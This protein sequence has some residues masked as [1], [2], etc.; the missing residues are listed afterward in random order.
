[1]GERYDLEIDFDYK[2]Q[3]GYNKLLQPREWVRGMLVEVKIRVTNRSAKAFP[4]AKVTRTFIE[5]GQSIGPS[6]LRWG[7]VKETEI[8]KLE[9]SGSATLEPLTF[10]PLM[11]GLCEVKVDVEEPLDSEVWVTGWRQSIPIR[12][13]ISEHFISVRRQ[14]MEI[15]KLLRKLQEGRS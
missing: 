2:L 1:M 11:E 5:H 15:I 6:P 8:P 10:S 7:A 4:G 12:K 3:T 13:E 9:P 14:E